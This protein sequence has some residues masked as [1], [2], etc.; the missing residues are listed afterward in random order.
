MEGGKQ[1]ILFWDILSV[2]LWW[3]AV[4][5]VLMLMLTMLAG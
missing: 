1:D 5:M 4:V 3:I 2:G